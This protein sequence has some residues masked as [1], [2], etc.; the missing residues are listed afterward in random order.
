MACRL[1][2]CTPVLLEFKPSQVSII[3]KLCGMPLSVVSK[4]NRML[5]MY[6]RV[7]GGGGG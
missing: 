6:V 2:E 7:F 3:E 5:Q 1:V 4:K